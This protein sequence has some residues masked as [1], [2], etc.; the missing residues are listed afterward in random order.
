ML[1]C[2]ISVSS[3]TND[4]VSFIPALLLILLVCVIVFRCVTILMCLLTEGGVI[5][6]VAFVF[7]SIKHFLLHKWHEKYNTNK[8]GLTEFDI[9]LGYFTIFF[10]L[11]V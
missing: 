9:I 11:W 1:L 3:E 6:S 8:V 5:L 10:Y 2:I 7:N 4:A